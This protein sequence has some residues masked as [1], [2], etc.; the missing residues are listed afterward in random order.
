[1]EDL[2]KDPGI[3]IPRREA[4]ELFHLPSCV[5]IF[6]VSRDGKV[7]TFSE[8]SSLRIFKFKELEESE[9]WI[10]TFIQVNGWTHPLIP[11]ASPALE[12]ANGAI[13]FPDVYADEPGSAVGIVLPED[14]SPEIRQE[15][16]KILEQFT[17]LKSV[18]KLPEDQQLGAIGKTLVKSAHYVCKGVDFTTKKACDL[19]EYVGEK[20]KAKIIPAEEDAKIGAGWKYSAKGAKYATHATVKVSGFVANRVGKLT[21]ATANYLASKVEKPVTGTVCAATGGSAATAKKSGSMYNLVDAAKGG[22]IAFGTVYSGLEDS[23][24]VLG[25]CVKDKSVTIVEHKYGGEAGKVYGD[26]MTAA[27]NAAMTYMNVSSLGLKGIAKKTAKQTAKEV[28]KRVIDAHSDQ[29]AQSDQKQ[30]QHNQ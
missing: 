30:I 24:K 15:L 12:A 2:E 6:F 9:E 20:Q 10:P 11:G 23:A 29:K 13:M 7:S 28:G 25:G 21:K 4:E 22:L 19:I 3:V 26:S 16:I 5:Q 27:G 14:I 8:P 17:A 18:E 1:M